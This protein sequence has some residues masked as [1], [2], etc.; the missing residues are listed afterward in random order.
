MVDIV[1]EFPGVRA[2]DRVRF[3]AEKGE[4]LALVG[5]NG[6]G[7]STLMKVL[8][9]VWPAGSYQGQIFLRG[10]E[11]SFRGPKDAEDAG[12]AIIH[13]ELNLVPD[14]SVAEN[15]FLN[16]LPTTGGGWVDW[17]RLRLE[18]AERLKTLG[19]S[20]AP[21]TR[22]RDLTVGKQQLVEIAK[23]LSINAEVLILDEPTSALSD[24]EVAD[25]FTVL[26]RLKAQGTCLIY[27]SH[28]MDEL[29][30]I[31]DKVAV[32][33]DGASVGEVQAM[34]ELSDAEIIARMVGRALGELYPKRGQT[35]G[36]PILRIERLSVDHPLL[37]GEREV[38]DVSFDLHAGE[39]LGITGLMGSGR[40]ELVE[41][42]FGAFPARTQG[43]VSIEGRALVRKSP[44][45]AIAAGIGLLTEDRKLLGLV[46]GMTVAENATLAILDSLTRFGAID[47]LEERR[48]ASEMVRSLRIKTPSIDT[49]V[50]SLSGGNQQKVVLARWLLAKPKVL[51]LDE[52]TRGVDV[53][54]KAEIYQLIDQLARDGV[55]III[56]SS[57]LPEV[58]GMSDRLLVM[59]EGRKVAELSRAEATEQRVMSFAT[60]GRAVAG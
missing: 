42:I 55:G 35:V 36:A 5:E 18:T 56:I 30:Q 26:L 52:P 2:L 58:L 7:K 3:H 11:A 12:V 57:E 20:L 4:I 51:I 44:R 28:K 45:D 59:R 29:R 9:G 14:L 60:L 32:L 39:I 15:V 23:A 19:L 27:I 22:I 34:S 49:P 48:R 13:Q 41:G 54:A 43:S 17:D 47:H 38:D 40:T 50:G 46:L 33:R 31:A 10:K 16:R 8:S 25:L 21:E 24:K 6:A 37:L 53:G 1:K